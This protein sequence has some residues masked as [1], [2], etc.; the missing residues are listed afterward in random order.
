MPMLAEV[1]DAVVG[2]DTH[3]D[4][5]VAELAGPTGAPLAIVQIPNTSAGY[6]ELLAW[7]AQHTPG[8]RVV[9]AIE[10]TRSFGIGLA[11][12]L[13]AAGLPVIECEQPARKAR[14]GR[15]KSDPIDAHLA[16][17]S[18]LQHDADRLPTPRADG[19]REALRILLSARQELSTTAT[20][21]TNRL[22]A[23]LLTGPDRDRDLSRR[24]ALTDATLSALAR[25]RLPADATVE[26]AIRHQEIRRLS[27]ALREAARALKAN[28]RQLHELVDALAP[29]LTDRRGL[30]PISAA[31]A[32]V[33]YSHPGRVR[34]EAAFAALAGTSPLPASSGRTV[35]H[36]LNRG[37]DRALNRA[38][39]TIAL[40]RL[41]SCERTRSYA[42]RRS[43]E[44]KTP[45]EI[46]RA[47]KR[48]IT[49][50]LYRALTSTMTLDNT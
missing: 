34:S 4:V 43:A 46:R 11:R 7:I 42:A 47:L 22:R 10:G 50:E 2:I 40:T 14:R 26:Q 36:R 17:L 39:H 21:Q 13:S 6:A 48:Y 28:R 1:V 12:A 15:G 3:R 33:S 16:V 41:R 24:A 49:R 32:V 37:G 35:R 25:R 8:P 45:R 18:V 5:H 9:V 30:G 27:V 20:A 38:V 44:G 29:G 31:Q 19:T 23:L